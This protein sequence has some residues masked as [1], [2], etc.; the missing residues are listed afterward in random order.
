Q[1]LGPKADPAKLAERASELAE[2]T[3]GVGHD[4]TADYFLKRRE[5]A[6]R[7]AE[8]PEREAQPRER[9]AVTGAQGRS[10]REA[11][12]GDGRQQGDDVTL[13]DLRALR[14]KLSEDKTDLGTLAE[15]LPRIG[16]YAGMVGGLE[17]LRQAVEFLSEKD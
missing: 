5:K 4:F 2:Q 11:A 9:T 16:G 6:G 17:R 13:A 8:Q 15:L 14:S 12:A 1:E 10:A 7:A 3:F